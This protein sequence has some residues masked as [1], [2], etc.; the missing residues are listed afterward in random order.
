[1]LAETTALATALTGR[2]YDAAE[3]E[4]LYDATGGFPLYIVEAA[5]S[6]AQAQPGA[7]SGQLLGWMG[8]LPKRIQQ[9]SFSPPCPTAVIETSGN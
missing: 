9:L 5:R 1:M 8:I 2:G 3:A 4:L 6:V 7:S